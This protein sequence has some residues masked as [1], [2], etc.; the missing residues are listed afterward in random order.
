MKSV[1]GM[2]YNELRAEY[3]RRYVLEWAKWEMCYG[4]RDIAEWQKKTGLSLSSEEIATVDTMTHLE[5]MAWARE[6]E[7]LIIIHPEFDGFAVDA[8]GYSERVDHYE[9][10]DALRDKFNDL[11]S[12]DSE[13]GSWVC[14]W[15]TTIHDK[16]VGFLTATYPSLKYEAKDCREEIRNS[17]PDDLDTYYFVGIR[18]FGNWNYALVTAK[19]L[20]VFKEVA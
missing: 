9:I 5:I 10:D 8:S 17:D 20:G 6:V 4:S 12:P 19:R 18:G 2:S 13:S 15:S 7:R 11:V 1:Y 16:V 3:A 14:R